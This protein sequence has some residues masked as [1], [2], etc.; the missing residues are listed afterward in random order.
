[1]FIEELQRSAN[2]KGAYKHTRDK[3]KAENI[4]NSGKSE[5]LQQKEAGDK[6]KVGKDQ[7]DEAGNKRAGGFFEYQLLI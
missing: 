1:M 4:Q 5:N 7:T 2:N 3:Y 6:R